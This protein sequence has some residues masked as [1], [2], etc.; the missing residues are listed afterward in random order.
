METSI[1]QRIKKKAGALLTP[2]LLQGT[3]LEVRFWEPSTFIEIDLHLPATD[4]T[5][6]TE[7]PYVKFRISDLTFRDYTPFG[8]DAETRT[9]TLIIDAAH[10]GPGSEWARKLQKNDTVYYSKTDTTHQSP[11][12]TS[13]IVGLGDESSLGHL[14]AL[15]QMTLPITRFAG[16]VLIDD[17]RHRRAFREYFR[18]PLQTLPRLDEDGHQSLMDWINDQGYCIN[19]TMF[20][21]TGNNAMVSRL[22]KLLKQKGH[23]SEKIKVKGFWS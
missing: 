13:L 5:T 10:F 1:F 22:R 20:Y 16:A 3:V 18:S 21:L 2:S 4:M 9:C 14:L 23:P 12:S 7:V 17:G 11:D 6:W 19:H 15:Q 8:W